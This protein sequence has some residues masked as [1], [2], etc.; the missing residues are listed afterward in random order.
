MKS[1]LLIIF[2]YFLPH[3]VYAEESCITL[4]ANKNTNS[5]EYFFKQHTFDNM[6]DLA[7][8]NVQGA[9]RR[10]TFGRD[11]G[12]KTCFFQPLAFAQGGEG[13]SYWGW[14]MLWAETFSGKQTGGLFY[15]RMDGEV[16]VSSL[17]KRFTKLAPI[18]TN[19]R[20]DG[21]KII[22][23]W[24]QVENGVTSNM[25]AVSDDEGRSWHIKP[26]RS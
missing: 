20:L 4:K 5:G 11:N 12:L 19:F 1:L 14:H 15:A 17:P 2:C 26:A 25:Q 8:V 16:W 6:Q 18:N 22:V 24:Q 9:V 23:T 10:V 21:Q 3:S 7:I 13:A